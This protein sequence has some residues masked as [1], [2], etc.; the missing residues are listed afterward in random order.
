MW[1]GR[2]NGVEKGVGKAGVLVLFIE[3][4]SGVGCLQRA[5]VT[6]TPRRR[7]RFLGVLSP[8]LRAS[9]WNWN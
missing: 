7:V 3:V 1:K 4:D 9:R 2:E 6:V 8:A 5:G